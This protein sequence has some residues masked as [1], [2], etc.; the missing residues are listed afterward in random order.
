MLLAILSISNAATAILVLNDKNVIEIYRSQSSKPKEFELIQKQN[1]SIFESLNL[2]YNLNT[3]L[4]ISKQNDQTDSLSTSLQQNSDL[5]KATWLL[6]KRFLS[7]TTLGLEVTH[8]NAQNGTILSPFMTAETNQNYWAL[9]FDQPLFPNFLGFQEREFFN[10]ASDDLKFK[11]IQLEFDQITA[12][13]EILQNFWKAKSLYIAVEENKKL[14]LDYQKLANK[15]QEKKSHQYAAAGELEQALSEF[16]TKKQA[17]QNDQTKLDQAMLTLKVLLNLS[18]QQKIEFDPKVPEF[19]IPQFSAIELIKLKKY[20]QQQLKMKM[21]QSQNESVA[22]THLPQISL[23]GKYTQS[24]YDT[25]NSKAW[26]ESGDDRYRKYLIGLKLDYTFDNEKSELDQKI[27]KLTVDL[28]KNK[29]ERTDLDLRQQIEITK[30]DLINSFSQITSNQKIL[31]LRKRALVDISKNYFQG[32][33]D[34]SFL[35]DAYNKKNLAEV[36]LVNSQGDYQTKKMDY[37]ILTLE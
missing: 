17:L 19:L 32:R 9:N 33:T 27:K 7:G 13:K 37:E 1:S 14:I 30:T 4:D 26:D 10:S 20:Q 28:E 11:E 21:A 6:S 22:N 31:A 3:T 35:I 15:V 12:E 2:R 36:S 23:Y 29:L 18:D 24:G 5:N 25:A 34:I 16:E 8:L